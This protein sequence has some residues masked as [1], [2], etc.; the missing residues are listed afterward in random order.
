MN[1][2]A[3]TA[4]ILDNVKLGKNVTIEDFVIIGAPSFKKKEGELKTVIGENA[5]IRSHSIIYAGN[6]IGDNFQ[7]GNNVNIRE[8]NHIGKNVS[9][10]TKTVVEFKTKI[11][12]NVRVHSQAFIPEYCE[13]KEGCW[14][15]PNVVLTNAKYP[16]SIRSKEFLEGVIVGK[17]AIIGANSTILPGIRIGEYSV[18]GAGSVV[19]ENVPSKKVLTG[20]PAKII[21]DINN[22]KYPDGGKAYNDE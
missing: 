17:H 12:D 6:I 15:G 2:I 18:I 20:N 4:K 7:T 16:I 10:G 1:K 5:L 22:L 13:L 9:I 8:K 14:I 3:P 11:E 21:G 19:T